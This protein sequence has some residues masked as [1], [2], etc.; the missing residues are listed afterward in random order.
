MPNVNA[1]EVDSHGKCSSVNLTKQK[2]KLYFGNIELHAHYTNEDERLII[3]STVKV[4]DM[5]SDTIDLLSFSL[6]PPL[7]HYIYPSCIFIMKGS[8]KKPESLSVHELMKHCE[9]FRDSITSMEQDLTV[10]DI[11]LDEA[12]YEDESDYDDEEENYDESDGEEDED[13]GEEDW[14]VDDDDTGT[15]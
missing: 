4:E 10:Y 9:T 7:N 1:V 2:N 12:T 15:L 11:P 13:C 3:L 14:D 5:L 6:P 8:E